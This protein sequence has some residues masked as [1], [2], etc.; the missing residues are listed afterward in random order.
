MCM[1]V[2]IDIPTINVSISLWKHMLGKL[3]IANQKPFSTASLPI[4]Q[5][6]F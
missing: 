5:T 3:P 4:L 2:D 6:K 1:C